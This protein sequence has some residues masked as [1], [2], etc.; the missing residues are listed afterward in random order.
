MSV[1][2]YKRLTGGFST[3][4]HRDGPH[5][6]ALADRLRGGCEAPAIPLGF[7]AHHDFMVTESAYL[8]E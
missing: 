7:A 5:I 1:I 8:H 3:H 6:T 2:N 4:R